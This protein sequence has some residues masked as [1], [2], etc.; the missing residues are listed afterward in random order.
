MSELSELQCVFSNRKCIALSSMSTDMI[1][2]PSHP[3]GGLAI[4][5]PN[6]VNVTVLG[7]SQNS[8]VLAI[9]MTLGADV[10]VIC[11]MYLPCLSSSLDYIDEIA[12][13]CGFLDNIFQEYVIDNTHV[14]VVGDFNCKSECFV[15][16]EGPIMLASLFSKYGLK[17][18]DSLHKGN[19]N[20]TYRCLK[21][22][23]FIWI[24][25]VFMS[26]KIFNSV[27]DVE[28]LDS[29]ENISDHCILGVHTSLI[30]P[31]VYTYCRPVTDIDNGNT[32]SYIWSLSNCQNYYH[33]SYEPL[34]CMLEKMMH[35]SVVNCN[36]P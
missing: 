7:V 28:I 14:I 18:C 25:H 15:T 24:D 26:G 34:R 10:L 17:I 33:K 3:F 35:C 22:N 32:I 27:N 36:D 11:N 1:G 29:G 6:E 30:V 21:Q 13:I 19:I 8:R 23:V 12:S 31:N 5:V 20:Y 16:H 9:K 4:F 2:K